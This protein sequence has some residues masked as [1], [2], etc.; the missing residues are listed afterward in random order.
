MKSRL[1]KVVVCLGTAVVLAVSAGFLALVGDAGAW[2]QPG[3]SAL[4]AAEVPASYLS[5]AQ[6]AAASCPGLSWT[7]LA[8]IARVESDFGADTAVSSAGAEGP[9]QFL[10]ATFARYDHPIPAD[11]A[12]NPTG[13]ASPPSINDPGDAVFAAARLVCADGGADPGR[14]AT[15]IWDY[16]HSGA[17]V[18]E[19]EMYARLYAAGGPGARAVV[20]ASARSQLGVPYAW[21]GQTPGSAFDCSGLSQWAWAEA[22]VVLPRTAQDQYDAGPTVDRKRLVPGDLVFFGTSPAAVSHVGIYAGDG[23]M[24]DAPHPGTDVR[25]EPLA[26]FAPPF[27][28]ATDPGAGP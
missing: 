21:G 2:I 15:A 16:N 27:V 24:V 25:I 1:A 7:V 3:E 6:Q 17:Y 28:A 11:E 5:L 20:I 23:L 14:L 12:P 19:V 9:M 26:G 8:G 22:G 4:A 10:P 18:V 13:A